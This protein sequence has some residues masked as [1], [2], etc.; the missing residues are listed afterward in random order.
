MKKLTATILA[1]ILALSLAACGGN[2][3]APTQTVS[4]AT[5]VPTPTPPTPTPTPRPPDDEADASPTPDGPEL[6]EI[7]PSPFD[8]LPEAPESDFRYRFDSATGGM[9]ITGY[10][11]DW[12]E[13]RLP[14]TI[15]D[16]PVTAIGDEAFSGSVIE[17]VD[18]PDGVAII[19]EKAFQSCWAL[20][21]ISL[22]EGLTAIGASAF[23]H[24]VSLAEILL[25]EGLMSIGASTF[26]NCSLLTEITLPDSVEEIGGLL[27][28]GGYSYSNSEIDVAVSYKGFVY[29]N[30]EIVTAFALGAYGYEPMEYAGYNWFVLER[31]DGKVLLLS[32]SIIDYQSPY[33]H[34]GETWEDSSLRQYLNGDFYYSIAREERERIADTEVANNDNPWYGTAGGND[35]IDKIFFLSIEEV[36]KYFGDSGQLANRPNRGFWGPASAID[37]EYNAARV[38]YALDG[39]AMS[40]SLRSPGG[41]VFDDGIVF[42]D[43]DAGGGGGVRPALWL[44][45][46]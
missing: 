9:M 31:A 41:V 5:P 34:E 28:S 14:A 1:L 33:D 8:S 29:K 30:E 18:I 15:E 17:I 11:G 23:A 21:D 32:I 27:F 16:E 24:C 4:E 22:P 19:G 3:P 44:N 25:P 45:L 7:E 20:T 39:N 2:N 26:W 43:A 36:V 10:E 40:W 13:L 35:T 12:T 46:Q 38:A 6:P 37:D 42:F